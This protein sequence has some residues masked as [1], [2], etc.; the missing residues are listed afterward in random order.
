MEDFAAKRNELL[1]DLADFQ[2]S[3]Q[4]I[5]ETMKTISDLNEE[6]D[7]H[8]EMIQ[9]INMVS[10]LICFKK[11]FSGSVVFCF[12]IMCVWKS[13][14]PGKKSLFHFLSRPQI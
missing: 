12:M 7:A 14:F 3:K 4:F 5:E 8:S 11:C 13:F 6:K 10:S 2:Q 1:A 9:Q